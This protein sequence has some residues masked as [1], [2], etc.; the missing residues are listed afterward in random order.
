MA[1]FRAAGYVEPRSCEEQAPDGQK[2]L[3]AFQVTP[4]EASK[5]RVVKEA[6]EDFMLSYKCNRDTCMVAFGGGVVGDLVG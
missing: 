1:A 2:T 5:S 4:G 3:L 6:V